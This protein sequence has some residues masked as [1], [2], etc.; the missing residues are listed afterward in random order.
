MP[1]LPVAAQMPADPYGIRLKA[2]EEK[3]I[4]W[5]KDKA[6]IMDRI[7]QVEKSMSAG[8]RRARSEATAMVEG[9]KRDMAQGMAAIQSRLVGFE[10][11]QNETHEQVAQLQEDLRD[12][13]A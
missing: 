11:V 8:V 1:T 7:A 4:T 13:T 10:S 5:S 6:G 12:S 2:A 3:L 9:V